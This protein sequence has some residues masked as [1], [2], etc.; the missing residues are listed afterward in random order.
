M[1]GVSGLPHVEFGGY[2]ES[3]GGGGNMYNTYLSRYNQLINLD[4]PLTITQNV[5]IAGNNIIM[6]AEVEVT[7]SITTSNHQIIFLTSHRYS[8]EYFCTVG[9][10]SQQ[11]FDLLEVGQQQIYENIIEID[12]NWDLENMSVVVM[13]QSM[14]NN[15]ILQASS[16]N[17]A[18]DNLLMLN[19]N[20]VAIEND[21]D[22][23]G[24]LNPGENATLNFNLENSS[25]LLSSENTMISISSES[26]IQIDNSQILI[27]DDVNIGDVVNFSTNIQ[28]DQDISLGDVLINLFV[29]SNYTDTFGDEYIYEVNFPIVVNINLNQKNWPLDIGAQVVSSP[30]II[31]LNNDGS[32]EIIFGDYNGLL[33]VLDKDGNNIEGF[34]FEANDDIWASPAVGDID[35]DGQQE[36]V[37]SSKDKRLYVIDSYGQ[38][39]LNYNANQFLMATPVICQLDE[40]PELEIVISGYTSTGDVFAI[41]HDG[42]NLPGFPA[43][44]NEK[45]ISGVATVDM[46]NNGLDDILVT[47]ETQNML[48]KILDDGSIDTLFVA[49]DKFKSSPTVIKND[50]LSLILVA[51][52]DYNFYAFDFNGDLKFV[53]STL[54]EIISSAAI[55]D[56]GSDK[57]GIFFGAQDGYL[58]GI[59]QNGDDLQG[60]PINLG[61]QFSTSPTIADLDYDG[62]PEIICGNTN[63]DL[64]SFDIN[65]NQTNFFPLEFSNGITSSPS[66]VDI[67]NDGD[68]DIF[69]GVTDMI[70]GIDIKNQGNITNYWNFYR[71]NIFRSGTY[72]SNYS[73]SCS[74]PNQGDLNCDGYYDVTDVVVLVNVVLNIEQPDSF[75]LWASDLNFDN[76]INILDIMLLRNLILNN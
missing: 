4:S 42:T 37:I 49:Q 55:V 10:Y 72:I 75:E 30:A 41:N 12:E 68:L 65:G 45:V 17:I 57:I 52:K 31:D 50:F 62:I 15:R 53:Y 22:L 18:L 5:N 38:L 40:D 58:Y 24:N 26:Y 48:I 54:Y 13:V 16:S 7:E 46:N 44:I 11:P 21:D 23:D 33:H 1:Y 25:V 71:G 6:Q 67:D 56:I 43:S 19:T 34:P 69:L 36:I 35:N 29:Q 9:S 63:G 47:T 73:G 74:N 59:D 32:K 51:N 60:W 70:V 76:E 64:Y 66:I 14:Q 27:E 3:V 61:G 28:I 8:N 39:E 2:I 20:L